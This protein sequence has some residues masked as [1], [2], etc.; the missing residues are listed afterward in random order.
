[1]EHGVVEDAGDVLGGGRDSNIMGSPAIVSVGDE[2]GRESSGVRK[3][4]RKAA[5]SASTKLAGQLGSNR[6]N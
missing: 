5:L 4:T 6:A 2:V 1:M 3:S